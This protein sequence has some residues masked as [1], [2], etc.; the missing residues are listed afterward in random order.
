MND[1][2]DR[3]RRRSAAAVL[4]RLDRDTATRLAEC[5]AAGGSAIAER[6]HALE[7]EWDSDRVL[8]AEAATVGLGGLALAAL[9][10]RPAA[11]AASGFAAATLLLHATSGRHPTLPLWRRAGVRSSAEILR[12]FHALKT[13]RGDFDGLGGRHAEDRRSPR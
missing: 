6:L 1:E 9:L 7:R 11:L 3:V 5:V 2:P 8:E 10:G 4:E 12:E 13:L